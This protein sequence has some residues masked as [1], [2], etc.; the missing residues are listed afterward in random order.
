MI[1]VHFILF[2]CFLFDTIF[3]YF[4]LVYIQEIIIKKITRKMHLNFY[5]YF[6]PRYELI[7]D[8]VCFLL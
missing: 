2:M 6:E 7:M 5:V 4:L 8:D 1:Q 3:V